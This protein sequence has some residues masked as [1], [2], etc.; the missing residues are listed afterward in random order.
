MLQ[1]LIG[2]FRW[3]KRVHLMIYLLLFFLK[4][5]I[6]AK[7]HISG[8]VG[9][10]RKRNFIKSSINV[11]FLHFFL[12]WKGKEQSRVAGEN[13]RNIIGGTYVHFYVSPYIRTWQTFQEIRKAFN[14]KNILSIREEPR[15]SEQQFGNFQ[16]VN[17]VRSAK[18][19]RKNFGRFYYRFPNGKI[20][21]NLAHLK[22]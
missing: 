22:G 12:K 16:D 15:L 1:L 6:D 17:Q 2:E 10:V 4:F 3:Q 13:I 8:R 20:F 5:A 11:F 9:W 14:P 7:S 21:D 18:E 19:E